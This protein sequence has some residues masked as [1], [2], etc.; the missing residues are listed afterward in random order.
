MMRRVPVNDRAERHDPVRIDR[1]VAG[2]VVQLVVLEINRFGDAGPLIEIPRI[3][4]QVR[5]IHQ[6]S[7]ITFEVSEINRVEPQ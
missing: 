5:V 2:I 1:A 6:T 7:E 4:P 3:T